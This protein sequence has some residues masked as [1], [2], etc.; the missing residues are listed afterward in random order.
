MLTWHRSK[1]NCILMSS[2]PFRIVVA[3]SLG[4][5]VLPV[6]PFEISCSQDFQLN[7]IE[8]FILSNIYLKT[9][10]RK[11]LTEFSFLCKE[12]EELKKST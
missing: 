10:S 6:V 11:L 5:P 7:L 12:S 4:F 2:N 3:K 1:Q 9:I 8:H